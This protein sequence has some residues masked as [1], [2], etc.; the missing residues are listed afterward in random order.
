MS[1][2]FNV[3]SLELD[4]TVFESVMCEGHVEMVKERNKPSAVPQI[5][6]RRTKTVIKREMVLPGE[7][8]TE[9]TLP[10]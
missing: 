4:K 3:L 7:I 6:Q 2:S 1:N 10:S 9:V 8:E 5:K